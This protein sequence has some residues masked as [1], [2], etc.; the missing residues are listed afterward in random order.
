MNKLEFTISESIKNGKWLEISY[1][2]S[3]NETTFFW[4]AIKDIDLKKKLLF[5][6]MFNHQ[7]SFDSLEGTLKFDNILT[8]TILEFTKY[9]TPKELIEKIENNKEDAKWLQFE[10]FN[11]NIL[12]YYLKCNALDNDPCQESSFLITGVDKDTL[13]HNKCITLDLTQEKE[14]ISY[15]KRYD[16][17]KIDIV[18]NFA[19]SFLSIDCYGKKYVILY[20]DIVF[21]PSNK[22]LSINSTPRVNSSFL[23]EGKKRS[24]SNYLDID[25]EEFVYNITNDLNKYIDTYTEIIRENLRSGE[26]INQM[27]EFMILQRNIKANLEP[28]Y[29]IIS[30][31]IENNDLDYPLKAF[32]GNSNRYGA[33]RKEPDIVLFDDKINIDQ[34]RVIYNTLKNPI[35]YVQGPPGTGKTQTILNVILSA[36]FNS[37]TVLICSSN[38]KPMNGI[39]EKLSFSYDKNII[40]PFPS[41]RLGNRDEVLKA[42]NK[43]LE[44][45]NFESIIEPSDEI[46]NLIKIKTSNDNNKLLDHLKMYE[47]KKELQGR[48]ESGKRL[49]TAIN[50]SS[51]RLYQ[52]VEEEINKL[53]EEYNNIDEI[54]NDYLLKYV[55]TVSENQNFKYYMYLESLK[56]IKKLKSSR[57]YELICI[58]S[59]KDEDNK[60][61]EFNKW[62]SLDYN[63]RLLKA[64]F[65]IIVTT[66]I[67]AARLGTANHSFDLVIMDEAGQCDC[68]TALLPIARA[69][70]LLLVGDTNQLKPVIVLE[71][72]INKYLNSLIYTKH[73]YYYYIN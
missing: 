44:L 55:T 20:Y 4:V 56:Y 30:E 36:F 59:I 52:N 41:L 69:K 12:R 16:T 33:K 62:C 53:I 14:V 27:P 58:C 61:T 51:I 6:S 39:F 35:T 40:I 34:L 42:T 9:D 72:N 48:I 21:D 15:I 49:L 13:L 66:N 25:P 2:N 45:Y 70:Q 60:I 22:S 7:K 32:F 31:K 38:N 23:V 8:A 50:D 10:T 3:L 29:E 65:P 73:K 68:A 24:I 26:I 28:T 37:K 63:M 54:T 1:R 57:Y 64:V 11:N 71:N 18:N 43:I 67:S 46:I 47:E 19:L 17:K 5:V